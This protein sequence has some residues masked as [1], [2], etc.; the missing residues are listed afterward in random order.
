MARIVPDGKKRCTGADLAKA[1]SEVRLSKKNADAWLRD[2]RQ[3][4]K[5]LKPPVD[6]WR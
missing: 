3:G 1:L 4:R 5:I 2:L 6:R